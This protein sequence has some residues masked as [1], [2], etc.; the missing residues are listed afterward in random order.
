MIA[1]FFAPRG[2]AGS[3]IGLLTVIGA[4]TLRMHYVL[5]AIPAMLELRREI[6]LAAALLVATY[7]FEGLW[8]GVG[9]VAVAYALAS[10]FPV[11]LEPRLLRDLR[12]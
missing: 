2:R 5:F 1:A 11:L 4:P 9:L 8:L 7:T 3:W 6:A 10:R 12:L